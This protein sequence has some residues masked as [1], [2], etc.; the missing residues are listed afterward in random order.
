MARALTTGLAALVL[1]ILPAL[2]GNKAA[3]AAPVSD[4]DAGF[5]ISDWVMNNS[6]AMTLGDIETF[7]ATKGANCVTGNDFY[8]L[9]D[10]RETTP[11]RPATA[12]C[13][14]GY[15]GQQNESAA[16]IIYKVA[17][18]CGINPQV[19]L[20]ML[21]KEQS[22]LT[23]AKPLTTFAKA[24]GFACPDTEAAC[25]PAY[26]GFANQVYS[27]ASQLRRYAVSSANYNF[28]AGAYNQIYYH[29]DKAR[30]GYSEVFI[31][32]QATASLYNYTPFQPNAAA[33]AAGTGT[34]DSCSSYG[35]RNFFVI[36]KSYFGNPRAEYV[37]PSPFSDVASD[38]Q[39]FTEIN[40]LVNQGIAN[41]WPDGTFRPGNYITRDSMAAFLF[42]TAGQPAFTPPAAASF[43]DVAPG[44]NR[45][46]A[47]VEWLANTGITGGFDD[48]TFRPGN[49][50]HRAAMAAFLF[51]A[52]GRPEFT[53]PTTPSFTDVP[54]GA[55]FFHEIEWLAQTGITTGW[56]DGSFRPGNNVTR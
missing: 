31:Q 8:C 14:A 7:I 34:G 24:L 54:T 22:L 21:Q 33:I 30:C 53:P 20:T 4:W 6:A 50:V 41:G 15:T 42:R 2:I 27:A 56:P 17:I 51:R 37:P 36:F 3:Q 35:N 26:A 28:K 55:Q 12:Y 43:L 9:K 48:G 10:Y 32:N 47:E 40:W 23:Q 18:A 46:F 16:Q 29:S 45:F 38:A 11:N 19:L 5:I 13:L 52:A 1:V 39:F 25:D 49:N 44:T